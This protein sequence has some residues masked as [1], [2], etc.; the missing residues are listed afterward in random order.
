MANYAVYVYAA[1]SVVLVIA[2]YAQ[3]GTAISCFVCNSHQSYD[4][5]DCAD[6]KPINTSSHLYKNCDNEPRPANG[7]E[8]VRCRIQVQEV[9]KDSRIIRSCATASPQEH[10]GVDCFDRTG[11]S[12]IKLR[13]CECTGDGC[14]SGATIYASVL[15]LAVSLLIGWKLFW[16]SSLH[17]YSRHCSGFF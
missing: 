15:T 2:L 5:Q 11:T 13:F 12:K 7:K 3:S 1:L 6:L 8:Y 4:G 17:V 16:D 10:K 14:N 9:E